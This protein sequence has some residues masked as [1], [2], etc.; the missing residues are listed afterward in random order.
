MAVGHE[1]LPG[2]TLVRRRQGQSGEL[3]AARHSAGPARQNPK[4][5]ACSPP[6]IPASTPPSRSPRPPV[7]QHGFEPT[8]R[9]EKLA[10]EA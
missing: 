9:C 7:Q 4:K 3:C 8:A 2:G 1:R 5:S 6:S 10:L